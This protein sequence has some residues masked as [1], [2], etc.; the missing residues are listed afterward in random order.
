MKWIWLKTLVNDFQEFVG[1][2]TINV[3]IGTLLAS[4][5][6]PFVESLVKDIFLPPIG[7]L[8]R[9]ESNELQS[10][11]DRFIL[12]SK[13]DK[14]GP[15]RSLK[16]AQDDGATTINYGR[17]L[18]QSLT[19]VTITISAFIAVTAVNRIRKLKFLKQFGNYQQFNGYNVPRLTHLKR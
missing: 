4:A 9:R 17:F 8:L 11:P 12:L 6:T 7:L 19:L 14:G 15:Y 16:H 5:M 1:D 10:L 13:G 3:A 18:S 2:E